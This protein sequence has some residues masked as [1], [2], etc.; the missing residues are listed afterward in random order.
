MSL[1]TDLS[2]KLGFDLEWPS[3]LRFLKS[4]HGEAKT[5][6]AIDNARTQ[7]SHALAEE[8]LG[9]VD[10][11][12]DTQTEVSRAASRARSRQWM[13]ERYNAARFGQ[14]KQ[15]QVTVNIGTLHLNALR[16][17]RMGG[18]LPSVTL[19]PAEAQEDKL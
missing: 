14:S 16:A 18:Q 6:Q 9:I 4:E 3:L 8:A 17:P 12:A 7:C 19:L 15:A 10:A 2:T 5:E 1:A 11:P 13:A